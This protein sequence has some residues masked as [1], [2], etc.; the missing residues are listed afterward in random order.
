M[1]DSIVYLVVVR[2]T[3]GSSHQVNFLFS[4]KNHD[5]ADAI[6]IDARL[7]DTLEEEMRLRH[8]AKI[9][10]LDP[11]IVTPIE[12]TTRVKIAPCNRETG[13]I[14]ITAIK[15]RSRSYRPIG[16]LCA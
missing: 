6:L 7:A 10:Q 13:E 1:L 5:I 16:A 8:L 2:D 11:I 12:G 3:E 4:P 15:V 14:E 9:A